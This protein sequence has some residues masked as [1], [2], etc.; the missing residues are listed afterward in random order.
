MGIASL[1]LGVTS[2]I[3]W[4]N[5]FVGYPVCAAGIILGISHILTTKS[6][7]RRTIAGIGLCSIGLG[8]TIYIFQVWFV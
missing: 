4:A 2:L 6:Y 3:A 5:P 1:T 7:R 8:I